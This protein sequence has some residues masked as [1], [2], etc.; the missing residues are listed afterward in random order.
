ME[1]VCANM[2]RHPAPTLDEIRAELECFQHGHDEIG[3]VYHP[4]AYG[5]VT[6]FHVCKRCRVIIAIDFASVIEPDKE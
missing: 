4:A 1:E 6:C 2:R 5:V 3:E